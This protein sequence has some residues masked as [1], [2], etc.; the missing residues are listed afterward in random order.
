MVN[1]MV[2]E[3]HKYVE[4]LSL[5]FHKHVISANIHFIGKIFEKNRK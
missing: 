5:K 4:P 2:S 3:G 1:H